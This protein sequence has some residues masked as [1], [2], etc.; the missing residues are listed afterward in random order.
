MLPGGEAVAGE[1]IVAVQY[2][3]FTGKRGLFWQTEP[4]IHDGPALPRYSS[5]LT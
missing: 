5:P 2:R 4:V 3:F 1:Q